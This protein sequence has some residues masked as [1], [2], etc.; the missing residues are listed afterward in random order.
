MRQFSN[1]WGIAAGIFAVALLASCGGGSTNNGVQLGGVA[2]TGAPMAGAAITV[3]CANGSSFTTTAAAGGT[4][5]VDV[6]NAAILPCVVKATGGTPP[7][8][9]HSIATSVGTVNV[10]PLTNLVVAAAAGADPAAWLTAN[11]GTKLA[12]ALATVS[13]KLPAAEAAIVTSLR[14]A[15]YTVPA[16]GLMTAAFTPKDG[17]PLDDLL[18]AVAKGARDSGLSYDDLVKR[19]A[20]AGT[21][22]VVVPKTDV[23]TAAQVAAMPQLNLATAAVSGGVVAMKTQAGTSP[24]GAYVGGG[25]GNKAVLQLAGFEGM[26]LK[27][28]K[29]MDIEWRALSTLP[30]NA[31]PDEGYISLNMMIDLQCSTTPLASTATLA[32]ARARYRV[33]TFD[34]FYTALQPTVTVSSTF[35]TMAITPETGG[36]RISG[37]SVDGND[38][39]VEETVH[40]SQ[41]K[42]SSFNHTAYPNACIVAG[43]AGDGGM[44]RDKTADAACDTM[45]GLLGTAPAKCSKAHAGIWLFLGHSGFSKVSSWEVRKVKVND[46]LVTFE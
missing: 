10:T 43:A 24:V 17:D 33:L 29:G 20:A 34:P 25:N 21:T 1:R 3:T 23:I 46:R 45:S 35:S 32:D 2:A 26:K 16:S 8:T 13:A 38:T 19:V 39:G 6:Q 15:G 27:D 41:F 28:F 42:L 37:G 9:L 30:T 12:E 44:F 14:N 31:A 40:G 18:E 22:P 11:S 4:W 7:V 36:W 5:S